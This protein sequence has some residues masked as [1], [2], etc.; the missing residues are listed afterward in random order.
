MTHPIRQGALA[1]ATLL[2]LQ[3]CASTSAPAAQPQTAATAQSGATPAE[4][5]ATPAATASATPAPAAESLR[6]MT[7]QSLAAAIAANEPVNIYDNNRRERYEQGHIPGARWVTQDQINAQVLP[8]DRNARLVFY[9]ANERCQ[10]CHGAARAAISLG[11]QNVYILPAGITGW[12]SSGQRV[13]AGT[14]PT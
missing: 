4:T 11:Y 5:S 9:C 13:V 2:A 1:L 8:Q 3:G 6:E 7:V 12:T 10:A 14:N